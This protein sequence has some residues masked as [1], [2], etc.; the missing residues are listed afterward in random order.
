[1]SGHNARIVY[2]MPDA[3]YRSHRMLSYSTA[4]LLLSG[5]PVRAERALSKPRKP[6]ESMKLGS[7][8][9][10][11]LTGGDRVE[12]VEF[13]TY[14]SN[15]AKAARDSAL[16]RGKVPV[17][18]AE[19]DTA[20]CV[21]DE[22]LRQLDE[23]GVTPGENYQVSLFWEEMSSSGVVVQCRGRV[24]NLGLPTVIDFK[25][26]H[27]AD[28]DTCAK[29]IDSYGYDIQAAAY[30]RGLERCLPEWAG[31]LQFIDAFL[32]VDAELPLANPLEPD[33]E[34]LAMGAAKWQ[35]AVDIWATCEESGVWPGYSTGVRRVSAPSYALSRHAARMAEASERAIE[36]W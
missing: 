20:K 14:H 3:E 26:I 19:Y 32:E 24:D 30:L 22:L 9:D 5:A 10:E 33:P 25:T 17:K 34:Y 8:V 31:R 7:L 35:R 27:H 18:R 15:D 12:V 29:H 21:C 13:A 23:Q 11:I 16:A 28:D 2:G 6:T 1:M 4:C 36:E